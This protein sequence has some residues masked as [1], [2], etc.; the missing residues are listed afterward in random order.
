MTVV[1]REDP[2]FA[3]EPGALRCPHTTFAR[4]RDE[5]PVC[6]VDNLGC[7]VV[8]RYEDLLAVLHAPEVFSSIHASGPQ[9]LTALARGVATDDRQPEEVRQMAR[10]R[11]EIAGSAVLLNADP[12]VH[13]RQ[14]KLVNRAFTPRRVRLLEPSIRSIANQLVDGFTDAGRVELNEQF[15]VLLPLYVIAD[16]LGVARED[17]AT[18]KRWSD[19]FVMKTGGEALNPVEIAEML[20]SVNEFYDYF[21]AKL[22]GRRENPQDDLLSSIVHARIDGTEPLALDEMLQMLVQFL[23]AGNETTAK[24]IGSAM[25][26]LVLDEEMQER[27]RGDFDLI[28]PF[29]EEVVRLESPVQGL[30]RTAVVDTEVGGV[31]IE[32]GADLFVVFASGNRDE[33]VFRSPDAMQLDRTYDRPHLAFGQGEHY[34]LGASL[35]REEARIAL[36][37]LLTR[38]ADIRL[39]G[40][41]GEI[42]YEPTVALRGVR[43]LELIFTPAID[44]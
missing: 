30:F 23:V 21:T 2:L 5:S 25:V 44:S 32:A 22:E 26:E 8:T 27:L 14:R 43:E 17:S 20:V 13:G 37:V 29:V 40:S 9:S 12:P 28:P 35:A 18:F 10:R 11:V 7:Y 34:C 24:L 3:L 31:P 1:H 42:H 41:A 6:W 19:A 15:A 39:A 16:A 33:H 36:E 38:L 4:I